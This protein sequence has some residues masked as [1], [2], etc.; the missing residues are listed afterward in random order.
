MTLDDLMDF[1][2]G[3]AGYAEDLRGTGLV[4]FRGTRSSHLARLRM[5]ATRLGI[6]VEAY[7]A[8]IEAG[9]K[10]CSRHQRWQPVGDFGPSRRRADGLLQNCHRKDPTS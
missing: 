4:N 9:E 8:H 3:H 1:D 6:T 5:S 10:W 2:G 7:T